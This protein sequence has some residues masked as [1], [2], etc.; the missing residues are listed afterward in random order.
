MHK[1]LLIII[2]V[3]AAFFRLV[4][5]DKYPPG[6]TADEIQQGYTGYSILKT[7][8][9]EWGD[10][11]PINPRGFGDYKPAIYSYLTVPSIALFGFNITAIR[12]P[13]ALAGILTVAV[14]YFLVIEVVRRKDV[15]LLASFI[16]AISSWHIQYS[17][18]GWESNVGVFLFSLGLLFYFKALK[19]SRYFILSALIFGLTLYTYHTFKVFTVLFTLGLLILDKKRLL[20]FSRRD[21]ILGLAVFGIFLS[22]SVYSFLFLGAGRRASDAA[23]YN[24]ENLGELRQR[25]VTDGL[26]NP[27]NRV[28]NNRPSYVITKF[29]ENYFGYYST[30]FLVS[31]NRSN[32][33]LFNLP[34]EDLIS[35]WQFLFIVIGLVVLLKTKFDWAKYFWTWFFLAPIPAALTREYMYTQRVEN[36]LPLFPILAALGIV[37]SYMYFKKPLFKKIFIVVLSIW[38]VFTFISRVDDYLFR[39][40]NQP[41]G[42]LK[43]GYKEIIDYTEKNKD[44]YNQIIFTKRN[45]EPQIFVAFYTQMDPSYYQSYSKDW[46]YF[47][48]EGFKFLDMIN[49]RLGKYYFKNLEWWQGDGKLTKT[50][51]IT[52]PEDMP[53]FIIPQYTVKDPFGK[54]LFVAIDTDNVK[55]KP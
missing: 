53:D 12:L 10:F 41:L 5:L 1:Y 42:G 45:S 38:I 29:A 25:Q 24:E 2:I 28:V 33:T 35:L 34:G 11:L 19:N 8:R 21:L 32:S 40:F 23:I 48:Q 26:P 20:K 47:E 30:T 16:M 7:G 9:D 51:I 44:K 50:L 39:Q 46:K 17:R 4:A 22:I 37:Y 18:L 15:A 13:S 52:S 49:Y 27:W 31:P 6:I 55:R 36:F 3:L 43:Y 14:V 54:T